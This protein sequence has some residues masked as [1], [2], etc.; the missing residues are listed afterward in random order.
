M[1]VVAISSEGKVS[2]SRWCTSGLHKVKYSLRDE[3][4]LKRGEGSVHCIHLSVQYVKHRDNHNTR[5][6]HV[7]NR[8]ANQLGVIQCSDVNFAGLPR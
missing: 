2:I 6:E 3:A 8:H 5:D 7:V 1:G 4:S